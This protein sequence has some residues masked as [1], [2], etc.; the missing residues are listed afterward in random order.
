MTE[1]MVGADMSG[2]TLADSRQVFG[3]L[4][5]KAA[6]F[7]RELSRDAPHVLAAARAAGIGGNGGCREI[8][9]EIDKTE[10]PVAGPEPGPKQPRVAQKT[11]TNIIKKTMVAKLLKY[12]GSTA[13]VWGKADFDFNQDH[14]LLDLMSFMR[15]NTTYPDQFGEIQN[16]RNFAHWGVT[17]LIPME[18]L[19]KEMDDAII[20]NENPIPTTKGFYV[21][22]DWSD[23]KVFVLGDSHGSLHS[24]IDIFLDIANNGG[25][26]CDGKL[27]DDVA[28][29]CLGDLL[30]RSPY[31]LDV[32]Y[33]VLRLCRENPQNCVLTAGNHETDTTQWDKEAGT[34]LEIR[35]E[36]ENRC[37]DGAQMRSRM[38]L[39]VEKLP[40]SLIART[41]LGT[42]Q[43]NHGSFETFDTST[44]K[45]QAF[46]RFVD[47][48]QGSDLF[49]TFGQRLDN[50]LQWGDVGMDQLHGG[51]VVQANG[52]PYAAALNVEAYLTFTGMRM[53]VRGHSDVA[54][55][56]LLYK[57]GTGPSYALQ[58]QNFVEVRQEDRVYPMFGKYIADPRDQVHQHP[59][60]NVFVRNGQDFAREALYDMYTL[61]QAPNADNF[62]K[63]LVTEY[64]QNEYMHSV[65]V[66]SCPFS[67]SWPVMEM[68]SCYL[69]IGS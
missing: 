7:V 69:V 15:Q 31:T 40:A 4:T 32:L 18:V 63:N 6:R 37:Q 24:I 44:Q 64:N 20:K 56:S 48:E 23:K 45:G 13:S 49:Q 9:R 16:L 50:N 26:T 47:F 22:R 1:G 38:I 67:K 25:I 57:L 43:F 19:C 27:A 54:N 61:H 60:G 62:N 68:M 65:T 29:V 42:M 58:F 17:K 30:D 53:L 21:R 46:R 14:N 12:N 55:L 51:A 8:A 52:R 2:L 35:G 36:Y 66:S 11:D 33:I 3:G 5:P 28:V 59:L 39:A 41:P 10:N 34:M